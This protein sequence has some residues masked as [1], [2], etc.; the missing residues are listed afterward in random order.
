M[1][2]VEPNH[3][4]PKNAIEVFTQPYGQYGNRGPAWEAAEKRR[5]EMVEF[6][7][8]IMRLIF[9]GGWADLNRHEKQDMKDWFGIDVWSGDSV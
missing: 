1:T 6:G 5:D 9:S 7:L 3:L 8:R 2:S 4:V